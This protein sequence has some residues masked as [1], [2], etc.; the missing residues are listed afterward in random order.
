MDYLT[1]L[2]AVGGL[3][4]T[5]LQW[6]QSW[7][8]SFGLTII[9]FTICLKLVLIPLDF[10]QRRTTRVNSQKQAVLQPEIEKIKKKYGNNEQ[11]VNQKTMELYKANN[12]NVVGTCFGLLINMVVT[13]VIFFSLFSSLDTVSKYKIREEYKVLETTYVSAVSSI[14][15]SSD[16]FNNLVIDFD[17]LTDEQ[18][19]DYE[20]ANDYATKI[21]AGN[22]VSK[23]YGEIKEGFLWIKNIWQPDTSASIFPKTSKSFISISGYNF[24]KEKVTTLNFD[25]MPEVVKADESLYTSK[26]IDDDNNA[27]TPA[28]KE[29]TY[30]KYYTSV[31]NGDIAYSL[32]SAKD[33][34][35]KD[36]S[37]ITMQLSKNY[38]GWNGYYILIILSALITIASQLLM[39][40]GVK[41][42]N[43]KGEDVKVKNNTNIMMLILLPALM[44]YFTLKYTSAFSLYIIVNSVMS[45]LIGILLNL[46]MNKMEDRKE[47][48]TKKAIV[49]EYSR[50][51]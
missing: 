18:K 13:L 16:E 17:A 47:N 46:I 41:A 36:Y 42:K 5:I 40:V 11:M 37:T 30:Y 1:M 4:G 34:F 31:I 22:E 25:S 43:K 15:T 45:T 2:N 28:V 8:G 35:A 23:K 14:D 26:D 51:K 10:W 29:Y 38:N 39:N 9:V 7:V 44:I 12:Y 33:L 24:T 6:F 49:P 21:I 3:W 32:N 50:K 27:E 48:N 20:D 19:Q